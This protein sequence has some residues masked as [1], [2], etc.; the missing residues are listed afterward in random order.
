MTFFICVQSSFLGT[1]SLAH[2]VVVG[3]SGLHLASCIPNANAFATDA[4]CDTLPV[5][6]PVDLL[7]KLERDQTGSYVNNAHGTGAT[8][9][10]PIAI[11]APV[12]RVKFFLRALQH[13]QL[14]AAFCIPN[15]IA[16]FS[17]V[18]SFDP[19]LLKLT[20]VIGPFSRF[21]SQMILPSGLMMRICPCAL[22]TA[23]CI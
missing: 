4:G 23:N 16:C 7:G 18:A 19:S 21:C 8:G 22:P 10:Q 1:G 12:N 14:L 9:Y 20:V 11:R 15:T 5:G 6:I 13:R 3:A 2:D 17:A